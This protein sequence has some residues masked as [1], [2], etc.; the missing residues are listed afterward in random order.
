MSGWLTESEWLVPDLIRSVRFNHESIFKCLRI[1]YQRRCLHWCTEADTEKRTNLN[2]RKQEENKIQQSLFVCLFVDLL[3]DTFAFMHFLFWFPL[4][5]FV[6]IREAHRSQVK[7]ILSVTNTR[8]M[9]RKTL[10]QTANPPESKWS[11]W[12]RKKEVS[13]FVSR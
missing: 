4:F 9:R 11:E 7:K 2:E 13:Q 5:F 1:S 3:F 12:E 10:Y 8:W 6:F